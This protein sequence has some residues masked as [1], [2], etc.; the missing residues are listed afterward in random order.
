MLTSWIQDERDQNFRNLWYCVI[1]QFEREFGW[2]G[3]IAEV[4]RKKC[5]VSYV[6]SDEEIAMARTG[7]H[8]RGA[9]LKDGIEKLVTFIKG[10]MYTNFHKKGKEA[11][12]RGIRTRASP[13]DRSARRKSGVF[14]EDILHWEG[15][16][17]TDERAEYWLEQKERESHPQLKEQASPKKK[18]PKRKKEVMM[19][20]PAPQK[21][22]KWV[23]TNPL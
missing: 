9:P 10:E 13:G 5:H 1:G 14:P 22:P 2:E 23:V 20:A 8:L 18:K 19:K 3:V 17:M 4:I 15:N 12:S 11:H 21:K 7:G 6:E 16:T